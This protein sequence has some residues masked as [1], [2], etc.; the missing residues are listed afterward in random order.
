M[1]QVCEQIYRY[2]SKENKKSIQQEM[3][4]NSIIDFTLLPSF[5]FLSLY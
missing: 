2:I 5:N 1:T 3:V 4:I